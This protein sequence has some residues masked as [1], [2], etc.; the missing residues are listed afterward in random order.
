M[1][2]RQAGKSVEKKAPTVAELVELQSFD[3]AIEYL[4]E[5]GIGVFSATEVEEFLGDGFTFV[6]KN[7]LVNIPFV[8][9]KLDHTMS[10]SYDVPMTTVR[11]MTATNKRIKFV[12]FSTGVHNQLTS[13]EE[14]SGRSAVGLVA[15]RGLVASNYDVCEE[16]GH[17]RCSE[18]PGAKQLKATTFYLALED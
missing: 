12:D 6:E 2:T 8:I 1:A 18:H 11:A 5:R 16:C 15:K 13:F 17:A 3:G 9:L 7:A 14:R 10:P 4:G